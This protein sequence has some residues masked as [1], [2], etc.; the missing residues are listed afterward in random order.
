MTVKE[1]IDTLEEYDE[2]GYYV[3]ASS[4]YNGEEVLT[5]YNVDGICEKDIVLV[6]GS[7]V[8]CKK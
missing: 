7:G 4:F 6:E 5:V 3:K 1:L 2:D 8:L